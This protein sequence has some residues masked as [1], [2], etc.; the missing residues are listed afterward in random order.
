MA[1]RRAQA[2]LTRLWQ[3][4]LL[5]ASLGL[6]GYAAYLFIDPKPRITL[7]QRIDIVAAL[8][9]NGRAETALEQGN[10]LLESSKLKTEDQGRVHLLLAEAIETAQKKKHISVA[11]NYKRIVEQTQLA[12]ADGVA[13]SAD[14]YRRLG[15]SLEAVDH[16]IEAMQA[17]RQAMKLDKDASPPL[18]RKLI[19]L[20]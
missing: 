4:P 13:P 7:A 16:P 5:L 10:K 14:M 8:V 15:E 11:A 19:E 2:R 6:F 20:E 12:L 17:Y 18:Q 1:S 9:K 3:M